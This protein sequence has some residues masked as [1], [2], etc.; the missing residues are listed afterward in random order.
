MKKLNQSPNHIIFKYTNLFCVS[1]AISCGAPSGSTIATSLNANSIASLEKV[2]TEKRELASESN[3]IP[4]NFPK[5]SWY[6][7]SG[8]Q[9]FENKS[10]YEWKLNDKS[11][12]YASTNEPERIASLEKLFPN[13]SIPQIPWRV[14]GEEKDYVFL[15]QGTRLAMVS[16]KGESFFVSVISLAKTMA[17]KTDPSAKAFFAAD[18]AFYIPNSKSSGIYFTKLSAEN[19]GE[20][21]YL[22]VPNFTEKESIFIGQAQCTDPKFGPCLLSQNKNQWTLHG[23]WS[24]DAKIRM[25][26]YISKLNA[27]NDPTKPPAGE[28]PQVPTPAEINS[29]KPDNPVPKQPVAG[30]PMP[31]DPLWESTIQPLFKKHC[32]GG[33]C[34]NDG[35]TTTLDKVISSRGSATS[36]IEGKLVQGEMPPV[37]ASATQKSIDQAGRDKI[38]QWL[39]TQGK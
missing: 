1:L 39:H 25:S 20:W 6:S 33:G 30:M 21:R 13:S 18:T 26:A 28:Q 27:N 37:Y 34:H 8:M 14:I 4:Q 5:I 9:E 3:A 16:L 32:A 10:I 29:P 19:N 15:V 36:G 38:I 2:V 35:M 31:T 24:P 7:F 23:P 22:A 17:E 11:L 12:I